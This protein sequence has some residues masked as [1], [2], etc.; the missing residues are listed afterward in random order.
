[1][2][3]VGVSM[4]RNEADIIEAFVRHN[5]SVLD[6]MV[7]VDHGS[8]DATLDILNALCRERLPLVALRSE[9]VGYVQQAI[10]TQVVRNAFA[11]AR[12]D[13]VFPLDADE[14]LK[15][16]SRREAERALAAIPPGVHGL[17][18]WP[19]Y[20]PD[21]HHPA[22]DVLTALKTAR[23]ADR[24]AN[25]YPK[26]VVGAGFLQATEEVLGS[27]NHFV[28]TH[29]DVP[30]EG[31]RKREHVIVDPAAVFVAHVPIRSVEQFVAKVAIKKLGRLAANVD[32]TADAASQAAY[33]AVR[34]GA[35]IDADTL[36]LAALNWS[37]DRSAWRPM[38]ELRLVDDPFLAPI[39]LRYT[40]PAAA[41]AL[42]LVLSAIERLA[43]RLRTAPAG[44]RNPAPV[45]A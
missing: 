15:M 31:D 21:L 32:W 13:F 28:V 40:P 20:V 45:A 14:F 36:T 10:M 30:G 38:S 33:D 42:P 43:Q 12:A 39:S 44:D 4:V 1:M 2:K 9:A 27:G 7:V 26:A 11:S 17:M 5:L 22:R 41:Q 24:D 3:L 23:R 37:V 18:S 35:P 25:P 29:P 6:G 8:A 34:S 16:R 19:S